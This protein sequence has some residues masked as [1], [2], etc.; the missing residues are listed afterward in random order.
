VYQSGTAPITTNISPIRMLTIMPS[1]PIAPTMNWMPRVTNAIGQAHRY[2]GVPNDRAKNIATPTPNSI[3]KSPT[4]ANTTTAS[5][6]S[7]AMTY[8]PP[9][10][11]NPPRPPTTP[12]VWKN[13]ENEKVKMSHPRKEPAMRAAGV[14]TRSMAHTLSAERMAG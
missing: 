1:R 14:R 10:A 9:A 12:A 2:S 4:G 13:T 7:V 3:P 6:H 8:G 11:Q 5:G